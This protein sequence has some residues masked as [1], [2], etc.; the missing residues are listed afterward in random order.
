MAMAALLKYFAGVAVIISVVMVLSAMTMSEIFVDFPAVTKAPAA[1][2]PRWNSERLKGEAMEYAGHGS[3]SPIYPAT[4]GKE[5]LGKP[6]YAVSA[7]RINVRHA[8]QLHKLPPQLYPEG[9]RDNNY[10]QQSL[11]YTEM[12]SSP[13]HISIISRYEIY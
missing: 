8:M 7:E 3:L 1:E 6:A 9:E 2:T 13:P 10:P 11:S 5:L 12:S 4:P